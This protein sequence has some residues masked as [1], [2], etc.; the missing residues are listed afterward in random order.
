MRAALPHLHRGVIHNLKF[1]IIIVVADL[2]DRCG[3]SFCK[4]D[5]LIENHVEYLVETGLAGKS[6]SNPR[7]LS[8]VGE[9]FLGEFCK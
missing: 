4:G 7:E 1:Q 2:I 8:D 6:L 3:V 5:T 9:L